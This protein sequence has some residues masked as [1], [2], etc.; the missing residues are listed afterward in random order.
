V[1]GEAEYVVCCS[2]HVLVTHNLP[3]TTNNGLKEG[4]PEAGVC[5]FLKAEPVVRLWVVCCTQ[6]Q[7]ARGIENPKRREYYA[8]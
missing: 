7:K 8:L 2:L 6:V 1:L 5:A 3:R 4:E